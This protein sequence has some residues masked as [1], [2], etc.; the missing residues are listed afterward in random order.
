METALS[1]A[2]GIREGRLDAEAVVAESLTRIDA[3]RSDFEAFV[4]VFHR[5]ALRDARKVDAM[6]RKGATLPPFAGVPIAIKDQNFIRFHTTRFGSLAGVPVF[7]PFDDA[8]VSRIRK[9]GF[10]IV[11]ATSLSEFGSIPVTE[12]HLHPPSRNPWNV[13]H[14]PGGSSG[15]S[16]AAV[17]AGLVPIAHGADGGGS[18]RIPA[19]FCGLFTL[20]PTRGLLPNIHFA[21]A[22]RALYTDGPL[23]KGTLDVAAALDVMMGRSGPADWTFACEKPPTGLR[24]SVCTKTLATDTDPRLVAQVERVAQALASMGHHVEPATPLALTSDDFLP[25]WQRLLADIPLLRP[26]K[27]HATT[28]WLREEGMKLSRVMARAKHVDVQTAVDAWFD[29]VDI[30][31]LPTTAILAPHVGQGTSTGDP[32]AD[33]ERFVPLAA[34]TAAFNVSGQPAAN[35]PVGLSDDGLPMGV[36]LAGRRGS[37][38]LVLAV[39]RQLELAGIAVSP[40]L[41]LA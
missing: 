33:L 8:I 15:G 6:R 30:M 36:Q 25:I 9:A 16:A 11:G 3:T 39:C 22:D 28:K 18:L 27:A 38:A 2:R 40:E 20:K 17:A 31:V 21:N 34:Y 32:R 14:T 29:P 35:I 23:G 10:I 5:S 12:N 37:D 4:K 26:S 13:A 19:A 24:I 1:L 41:S 7:S